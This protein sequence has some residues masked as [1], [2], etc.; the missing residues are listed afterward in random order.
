[1]LMTPWEHCIPAKNR[2]GPMIS[3]RRTV[4]GKTVPLNVE[5][6]SLTGKA[7]L[8]DLDPKRLPG[9]LQLRLRVLQPP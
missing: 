9:N 3:D 6:D 5:A 4:K 8:P 7:G 1:M 2:N